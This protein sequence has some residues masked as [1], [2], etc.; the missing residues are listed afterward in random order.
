MTFKN[1]FVSGEEQDGRD[2]QQNQHFPW[3]F[4]QFEKEFSVITRVFL[5]ELHP[6]KFKSQKEYVCPHMHLDGKHHNLQ[7]EWGEMHFWQWTLELLWH[8][9]LWHCQLS[10]GF[11]L[12]SVDAQE[13][14]CS[15]SARKWV[16]YGKH[17]IRD[18]EKRN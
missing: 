2:E 14:Q 4:S 15:F 7:V 6:Q 12:S 10:Q 3:P 11:C 13:G 9:F 5:E 16:C 1:V 18:D 17:S 8:L